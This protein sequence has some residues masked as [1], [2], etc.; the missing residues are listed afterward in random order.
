VHQRLGRHERDE[1]AARREHGEGRAELGPPHEDPELAGPVLP[2][3]AEQQRLQDGQGHPRGKPEQRDPEG[4][5][6]GAR[7]VGIDVQERHD[8]RRGKRQADRHDGQA[9][10]DQERGDG[11][12]A[13]IAVV[14]ASCAATT[15]PATARAEFEQ[16]M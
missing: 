11:R 12:P 5:R 15:A 16:A 8:R 9:G 10:E 2:L 14:A 3:R 6:P 13:D 7:E 4:H 1:A